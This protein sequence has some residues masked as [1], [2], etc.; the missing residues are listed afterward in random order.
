MVTVSELLSS[1][2]AGGEDLQ[3]GGELLLETGDDLVLRLRRGRVVDE[4]EKRADVLRQDGEATALDLVVQ[5]LT[6]ADVELLLDLDALGGQ[7]LGVDLA[8]QDVLREVGRPDD[9]LPPGRGRGGR[10]GTRGGGGGAGERISATARGKCERRG[11]ED[12]RGA[13]QA[14]HGAIPFQNGG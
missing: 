2:A 13:D 14:L 1:A 8:E 12:R 6:A 10:P 5:D 7:G 9:D 4:G 3:L 11:Q